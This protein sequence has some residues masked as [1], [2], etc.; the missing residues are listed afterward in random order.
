MMAGITV[1]RFHVESC[2][3]Q[4]YKAT[5]KE[6]HLNIPENNKSFNK[7]FLENN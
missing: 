5:I 2:L 6:S 4:F 7:Q 1:D 3:F